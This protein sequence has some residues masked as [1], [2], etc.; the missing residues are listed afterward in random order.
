MVSGS[1]FIA[2]NFFLAHQ[3]PSKGLSSISILLLLEP[4]TPTHCQAPESLRNLV[5]L[6]SS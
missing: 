2:A 6:H 4:P 5:V 1:Q 3:I